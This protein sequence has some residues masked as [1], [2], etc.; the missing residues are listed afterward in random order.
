MDV[1]ITRC[2]PNTTKDTIIAE[3]MV[4]CW[5]LCP[6]LANYQSGE[7]VSL[8]HSDQESELILEGHC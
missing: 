5:Q 6:I 7:S 2:I 8:E 3:L 1:G 4:G